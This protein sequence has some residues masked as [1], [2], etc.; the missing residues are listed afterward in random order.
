[1]R[2]K[3]RDGRTP[4]K[5]K[6]GEV[7]LRD[8]ELRELELRGMRRGIVGDNERKRRHVIKAWRK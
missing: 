2:D 1:M 8:L 5:Q 3:R 6:T 7:E 4:D